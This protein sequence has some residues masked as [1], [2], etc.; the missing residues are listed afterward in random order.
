[1]ATPAPTSPPTTPAPTVVSTPPT[2]PAP[3]AP[4]TGGPTVPSPLGK[5]FVSVCIADGLATV[6]LENLVFRAGPWNGSTFSDID[7]SPFATSNNSYPA[8]KVKGELN[9]GSI[10]VTVSSSTS[11]ASFIITPGGALNCSA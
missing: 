1:M 4:P 8:L 5:I 9:G 3:T 7:F 2:T 11:S 10:A 6:G